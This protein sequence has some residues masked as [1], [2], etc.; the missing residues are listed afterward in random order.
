MGTNTH[1]LA[2]MVK[3]TKSKSATPAKSKGT[4]AV[5]KKAPSKTPPAKT[6]LKSKAPAKPPA[7]SNAVTTSRPK[8]GKAATTKKKAPPTKKKVP[9]ALKRKERFDDATTAE[10]EANERRVISDEPDHAEDD[11]GGNVSDDEDN[12]RAKKARAAKGQDTRTA[13]EKKEE[14]TKARKRTNAKSKRRGYRLLAN[15]AG[16]SD[17]TAYSTPGGAFDV[18]VP[19]TTPGEAIRACKWA[20]TQADK[21]TFGGLTEYEERVALSLESL[22]K[23][24]ARVLQVNGEQ[25][26]RRLV[27]ESMQIMVDQCKTKVVPSMVASVTRPLKRVQKYS[28]VAPH[29]LVRFSQ[30]EAN[31]LRTEKF[32]GELEDIDAEEKLLDFQEDMKECLV[33]RAKLVKDG[34][35]LRKTDAKYDEKLK[36]DYDKVMTNINDL[37]E[38]AAKAS[39]A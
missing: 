7:K 10:D 6:L 36:M 34:A 20:P 23:S 4:T 1:K 24:A 38:A 5:S 39:F 31:G 30:E 37:R 2:E 33:K 22:P 35:L 15:R 29:G 19:I 27:T 18:A 3:A 32:D 11:T 12:Q 9:G 25:Y 14:E 17:S 16:Y 26:L 28:F 8:R 21:P 13:K